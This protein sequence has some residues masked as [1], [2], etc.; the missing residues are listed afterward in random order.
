MPEQEKE[1]FIVSEDG[2]KLIGQEAQITQRAL[3]EYKR[4]KN[5]LMKNR[6]VFGDSK[7]A[8]IDNDTY[9][10]TQQIANLLG[11]TREAREIQ[12]SFKKMIE[13]P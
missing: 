9:K 12:E 11:N 5:R 4:K 7:I 1:K 2:T 6:R 13:V 3:Q 8:T 10:R